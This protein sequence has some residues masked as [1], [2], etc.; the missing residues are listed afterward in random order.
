MF[1]VLPSVLLFWQNGLLKQQNKKIQDQTHLAEA[2]RRSAQMFIMGEVLSD[3]NRE[4]NQKNI[5]SSGL[6][7]RIVSLS[8][9]MKPYRYLMDNELIDFPVSPE[10]GQLLIAL[11]KS[12]IQSS[13]FVDHILQQGNF[14]QAELANSSLPNTILKDINLEGAVLTNSNFVN[15]DLSYAILKNASLQNIEFTDAQLK[16]VDFTHAD[17]SY[18]DLRFA[19]VEGANFSQANLDHVRVDRMDWLQFVKT[20]AHV[21]G[22]DY[23]LENYKV[24]SLDYEG[25][26]K[27]V[28]TLVRKSMF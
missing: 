24:D 22:A 21:K 15:V 14:M 10:R 11:A 7:G 16:R 4:L 20:K 23:L 12:N 26:N 8:H 9:A 6:V 27:K 18:S 25:Y 17:L 1:A 13:F 5:L 19:K 28:P 2:S 3:I